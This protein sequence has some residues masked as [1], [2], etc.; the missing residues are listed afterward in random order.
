[1]NLPIP[2]DM[3]LS[4]LESDIQ[5]QEMIEFLILNIL[6]EDNIKWMKKSEIIETFKNYI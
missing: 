4:E 6:D 1:M 5:L 2:L 3:N